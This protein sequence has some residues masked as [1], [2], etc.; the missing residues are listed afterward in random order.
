MTDRKEL[1]IEGQDTHLTKGAAIKILVWLVI[2]GLAVTGIS[3]VIDQFVDITQTPLFRLI[4][5]HTAQSS[6]YY[7]IFTVVATVL[8]PLPTLPIDVVIL[9]LFNPWTIVA[10][11]FVGDLIGTVIAYGLA[12]R[13]GKHLIRRWFSPKKA[14]QIIAISES[15]GWKQYLLIALFPLVNTE[16]VAYAAGL[17]RLKLWTTLWIIAVAISYRLLI[18]VALL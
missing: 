1:I 17:S 14:H 12:R 5:E 9:K 6:L 16:L 15:V 7:L 2:F 13:F 10:L 8:V 4:T 11:R 18:V 3:A